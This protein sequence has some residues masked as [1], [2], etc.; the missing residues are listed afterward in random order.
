MPPSAVPKIIDKPEAVALEDADPDLL[1][2]KRAELKKELE[3]QLKMETTRKPTKEVIRKRKK[4]QS[5]SSSSSSSS[6]SSSSDSSSSSS[7]KESKR[8]NKKIKIK[9]RNSSSSSDEPRSKKTKIKRVCHKK[10]DPNKP[11]KLAHVKKAITVGGKPRKRSQSPTARKRAPVSPS[12]LGHKTHLKIKPGSDTLSASKHHRLKDIP[13]RSEKDRDLHHQR[14]RERDRERI[15]PREK[16]RGRSRSPKFHGKSRSPKLSSRSRDLG[17]KS[18]PRRVA[19][20]TKSRLSVGSSRRG[21]RSPDRSMSSTRKD[22][23]RH[24]NSRDRERERREKERQDHEAA[25]EKERQE[26]LA[27]CQE[28]QRERERLAREKA[29]RER[30]RDDD[31]GKSDRLLPRPAERAMALA[32][33]RDRSRDKSL[34]RDRPRSHPHGQMVRDRLDREKDIIPYDRPYERDDPRYDHIDRR[35]E[36]D[37]RGLIDERDRYMVMRR[38]DDS[39]GR[40]PYAMRDKRLERD[41]MEREM[42]M[43]GGDQRY[44]DHLREDH[45]E[46][47][48]YPR[49]YVDDRHRMEREREWIRENDLVHEQ[50]RR[51]MYD[52]PQER[53]PVRDW[54]RNEMQPGHAGP[55]QDNYV[56]SREWG[57]MGG[58]RQ[59]ETAGAGG[60]GGGGGSGAGGGWPQETEEENWDVD[61]KDWQEYHRGPDK[62]RHETGGPI[63]PSGVGANVGIGGGVGGGGGGGSGGGGGGGGTGNRRWNSWRGRRGNLHHNNGGP[64]GGNDYRRHNIHNQPGDGYQNRGDMNYN[65]RLPPQPLPSLL[66]KPEQHTTHPMIPGAGGNDMS[67]SQPGKSYFIL[68]FVQLIFL[69]VAFY[70]NL[71]NTLIMF[72]LPVCWIFLP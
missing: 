36:K 60:G 55:I 27:R 39:R 16:E 7:S 67:H 38:R 65:R 4:V 17:H 3:L 22:L 52:H 31:R 9:R 47:I 25:R 10:V 2:K 21:D 28:R 72:H 5:S 50:E 61:D 48:D 59:W 56:D 8:K 64:G 66:P 62:M 32:A 13:G 6:D 70:G 71:Q 19:T 37:D 54:D 49:G 18:S 15:R 42:Y 69:Y 63:T 24:G 20:P 35:Y 41:E 34:D 46:P 44:D 12:R 43:S 23:K 14:D 68:R 45:R 57:A 26:I 40:S 1:E 53:M 30:D 11:H 58:D 51:M 29:R 33:A